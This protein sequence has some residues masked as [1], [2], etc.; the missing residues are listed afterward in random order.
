MNFDVRYYIIDT[1]II[2]NK[3]HGFDKNMKSGNI[4]Y[5]VEKNQTLP[6]LCTIDN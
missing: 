2:I 4:L 6:I 5:L 3:C 1:F